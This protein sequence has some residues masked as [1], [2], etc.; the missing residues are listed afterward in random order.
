MTPAY[1]VMAAFTIILAL[2][3]GYA[4]SPVLDEESDE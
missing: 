4:I 2:M 1:A 3:A